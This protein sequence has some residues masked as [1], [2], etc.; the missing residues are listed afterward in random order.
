M[1]IQ[2]VQT[3]YLVL[4]IALMTA[5]FFLPFGYMKVVDG[6]T[7]AQALQPLTGLSG[8]GFIIPTSVA[9]LFAFLAIFLFKALPTQKLFVAL[10][11]IVSLA[12][13]VMVI[14][15]LVSKYYSTD[16][17]ATDTVVWGGGGLLLVGAVIV[18][19]AAY[20]SITRDQHLLSS[21]NRLR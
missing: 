9:I 16:P 12:E 11:A 20:R 3:L 14:Y 2:R 6:A 8:L 21:Y 13:I 1:V 18:D 5:F 7:A 19:I 17:T 10:S 4:S 15:V